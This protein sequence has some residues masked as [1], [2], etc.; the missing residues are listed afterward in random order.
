MLIGIKHYNDWV[1]HVI[2]WSLVFI[3]SLLGA[4]SRDGFTES[5]SFTLLAL[6]FYIL[7]VYSN[8]YVFIPWLYFKQ[9]IFIYTLAC[10]LWL[11]LLTFL[12][13]QVSGWV[14]TYFFSGKSQPI[15]LKQY[16][17]VLIGN[18]FILLFSFVLLLILR[19]RLVSQTATMLKMENQKAAL[20][21]LQS[22]VQPHFLF[23][24]LNNIY[25]EAVKESPLTAQLIEKL[26]DMMRY[27]T[28]E[29]HQEKVLLSK[30][31]QFIEHCI[32]LELI[33][34]RYPP[35]IQFTRSVSENTMIPPMLL[36][37]FIENIF[38]HGIDKTSLQNEVIISLKQEGQQLIFTTQNSLPTISVTQK[39]GSGLSNLERRLALIYSSNFELSIKKTTSNF[40]ATLVITL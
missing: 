35:S 17:T 39:S 7:I 13:A 23:N 22:R 34:M 11:V 31:L 16:S 26:S 33:R 3:L 27:F 9:G 1:W 8:V 4:L 19:Y 25:F 5:L 38:K 12:R 24:T 15:L 40:T 30:E 29:S 20:D 32:D 36:I 28:E 37:T 10:L 6:F 14:Y 18:L 21:L 2:G